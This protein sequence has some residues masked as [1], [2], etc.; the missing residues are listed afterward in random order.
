MD[1]LTNATHEDIVTFYSGKY[2]DPDTTGNLSAH[3]PLFKAM[4]QEFD[5]AARIL[6]LDPGIWKILTHPKRQIAVSCPIQMDTGEIEVFTGYRG[7]T[8]SRWDRRRVGSGITPLS[9]S[10]K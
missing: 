3:G 4:L 5:I 9:R 10:T 6:N 2:Y 8:T 7:S 1:D